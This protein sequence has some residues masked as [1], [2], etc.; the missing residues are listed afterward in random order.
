MRASAPRSAARSRP[1]LVATLVSLALVPRSAAAWGFTAHRLVSRAAIATLPEPLKQLFAGNADLVA[2]R[3]LD[4]DLWRAA[5]RPHEAPNHF[6]DLDAFGEYPFSAIPQDEAEHLARHGAAA[7]ERGRVPWR[8]AEAQ[9]ALVAAFRAGDPQAALARAAELSHY[10]SDAHVPLHAVL[11]YD[12]QLSGQQGLHSRWEAALVERF[13]RQLLGD[14]ALAPAPARA[15]GEPVALTFEALR[16]SYRAAQALLAADRASAGSL[17]LAATPQ[18]ERYGDAYYSRLYEAEKDRL[19][20]RLRASAERVAGLWLAAWEAAGRPA[21][22][23]SWR[24]AYVRGRSRVV[25]ATL[26]GAGASLMDAAV[27]RGLMP[28]LARLRARGATAAGVRPPRPAK[29]AVGHASLYTGAW[30]DGTGILGNLMPLPGGTVADLGDGYSA[31]YLRAEPLWV[32]AARQGLA[33]TVVSATQSF[34]FEPYLGERRFGG[35]YGRALTLIDGYQ[36]LK[37]FDRALGAADVTLAEPVGWATLPAHASGARELALEVAGVRVDGL[38]YDDRADPTRGFDTLALTLDKDAEAGIRLKPAPTTGLDATAFRALAIPLTGGRAAVHFR[39]FE[40]APDASTLLLYHTAPRVLRASRPG[41]EAP[42]LEATGGFVGNGAAWVY[43]RGELGAPLWA[44]GDGSAERRYLETLV[45][46]E[47]QLARITDFAGERTDWSLLVG[48]LPF[49]DE[50]F[51]LWLGYL[52]ASLPGHDPALAARLRPFV[53]SGLR[54]V[55]RFIARLAARAEA[56][57]AVLALAADHGFVSTRGIVRPN[58]LLEQAAL[59]ARDASG[60][61]DL[62]RTRALYLPGNSGDVVVNV[63]GLPG[64]IV[65]EAEADAVLRQAEAALA[66]ACEPATGAPLVTAFQRMARDGGPLRVGGRPALHLVLAPGYG[67][68]GDA[69][70]PAVETTRPRG[71]HLE[72]DAEGARAQFVVTGPGVASGAAL[73]AIEHVDIAP[74]LAALL[75]LE[76]PAHAVGRV[77]DG[78]LAYPLG[79]R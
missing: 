23:W 13:E 71:D 31:T 42:L 39:L 37:A 79:H 16:E 43:G 72:P 28:E 29:T 44:G 10:V 48:Y 75:G 56:S 55:D 40:L 2:E 5:G 17:D 24:A 52:D 36:N 65:P 66:R 47:R 67:P 14:P 61:F 15:G 11:N 38:L 6:L 57:G 68:A 60:A 3:S 73:G 45:L 33:A 25:L 12:G 22:E 20:E 70:G 1:A 18:D 74:T 21:L 32:T 50:F 58:V 49:P 77:L 19:R 62:A 53:D 9:Q 41:L 63:A 27:A 76:P 35:D 7:R 64:G 34:P 51:H 69:R 78:A 54:V 59:V 4:P 30:S 26:D 8:A 46:V